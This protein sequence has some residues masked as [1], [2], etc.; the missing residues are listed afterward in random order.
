[1]IFTDKAPLVAGGGSG[2]GRAAGEIVA[3][4][5]AAVLLADVNEAAQEAAIG[6]VQPAGLQRRG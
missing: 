5:G 3:E 2:I 6:A 1:M 4:R